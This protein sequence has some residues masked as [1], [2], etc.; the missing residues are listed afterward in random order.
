MSTMLILIQNASASVAATMTTLPVGQIVRS[1][2]G[3]ALLGGTAMF[4]RPLLVGMG[5]AA[6]LALRPRSAKILAKRP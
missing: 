4:F 1:A 3:L 2:A 6:M 5:R